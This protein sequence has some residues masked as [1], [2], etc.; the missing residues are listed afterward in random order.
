L[1]LIEDAAQSFGSEAFGRKAGALAPIACTSF[2]PAK[3]LGCYG[4]GGAVFTQ[5]DL[6]AEKKRSIRNHGQGAHKYENLRIGIN[7][8]LDTLQ[9]AI[10]LAKLDIFDDELDKRREVA[11]RYRNLLAP[12]PDIVTPV[13][14]AGYTSSWAQYSILAHDAIHRKKLM[15]RLASEGI[16]T[17]IYY[18][19]PLHLQKAFSF[20]GYHPGDFPVAE[21][22]AEK[23]F[24][25]PMHPYLRY[26]SQ[27][28]I[29]DRLKME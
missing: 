17:A 13:I 6:L 23:I 19:V 18:P 27:K 8:R 3:P 10:L 29:I 28:R 2:F 20:L 14:P 5:D 4:D 11:E 9:A 1:F 15:D 26:D 24:S 16:P 21:A 22:V 7:G 12:V 25:L